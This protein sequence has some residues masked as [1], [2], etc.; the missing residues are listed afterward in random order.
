M[1]ARRN[2]QEGIKHISGKVFIQEVEWLMADARFDEAM[3][4]L[5]AVNGW[6][7][8]GHFLLRMALCYE[9]KGDTNSANFYYN[10][11][12]EHFPKYKKAQE[13][14]QRF[15]KRLGELRDSLIR[16][17]AHLAFFPPSRINKIHPRS[18]MLRV[19]GRAR[20][21]EALDLSDHSLRRGMK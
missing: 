14:H 10:Q 12:E 11:L 8:N 15:E 4:A 16:R 18:S 9:G 5:K 13:Y 1:D 19:S 7:T 20:G 17:V 3:E 21:Y 6:E 2:E